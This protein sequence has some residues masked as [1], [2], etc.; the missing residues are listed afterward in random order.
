MEARVDEYKLAYLR[1]HVLPIAAL[2]DPFIY[3]A[4]LVAL[5][6][7][8]LSNALNSPLFVFLTYSED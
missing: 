7:Y 4:I 3:S 6:L 8:I 2:S 5:I 1:Q